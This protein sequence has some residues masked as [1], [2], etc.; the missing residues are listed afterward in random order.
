MV[1]SDRKRS[2]RTLAE[3]TKLYLEG[4]AK[5]GMR[6][7]APS[8][9]RSPMESS[10]A[11]ARESTISSS[12]KARTRLAPARR[13]TCFVPARTSSPPR[14]RGALSRSRRC[15]ASEGYGFLPPTPS[16]SSTLRSQVALCRIAATLANQR[17]GTSR[18]QRRQES[19]ISLVSVNLSVNRPVI[20]S[21]PSPPASESATV[22]EPF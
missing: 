4:M 15:F 7:P 2:T 22:I 17:K 19:T 8:S 14:I 6:G 12:R 16:R 11:A 9:S 3:A 13:R 10:V 20:V 1:R 18:G 5:D 21:V